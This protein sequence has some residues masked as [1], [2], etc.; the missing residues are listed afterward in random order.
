MGTQEQEISN[1]Q[2]KRGENNNE[3]EAHAGRPITC[4]KK[5]EAVAATRH[6]KCCLWN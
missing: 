3:L 2:I 6:G 5:W 1:F 4:D